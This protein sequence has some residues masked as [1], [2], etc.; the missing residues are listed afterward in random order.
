MQVAFQ[1]RRQANRQMISDGQWVV[2]GKVGRHPPL[3]RLS[4]KA[5]QG[6]NGKE[7]TVGR[8]V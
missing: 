4:G 1:G 7:L 8:A 3:L 5:S 2:T 6:L